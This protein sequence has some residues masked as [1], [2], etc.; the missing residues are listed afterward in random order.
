MLHRRP[1]RKLILL[2]FREILPFSLIPFIALTT[3]VFIQQAGKYLAIVLS[4]HT[5]GQTKL[6]FLGSLL[7]GIIIITLP[8]SLLLGAVIACSRLSADG[9]LT[10]SQSLGIS[11]LALASPF[12]VVGLIGSAFALYL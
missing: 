4:F 8:V 12:A 9:E 6:I 10:A 3:L 11:P 5:S 1:S 2:L 7:P